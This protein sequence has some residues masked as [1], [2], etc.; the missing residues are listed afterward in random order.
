LDSFVSEKLRAWPATESLELLASTLSRLH[1][2]V[3]NMRS[4]ESKDAEPHEFVGFVQA[5]K[6]DRFVRDM[7]A[8]WPV[9]ESL[10]DVTRALKSSLHAVEQA[11]KGRLARGEETA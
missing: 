10:V 11:E 6:I 7:I 2:R 8:R 4:V 5:H 1:E 9:S 3:E